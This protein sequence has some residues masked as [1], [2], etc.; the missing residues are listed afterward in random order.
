MADV[1]TLADRVRT[2]ERAV[3]DGECEF[4][5]ATTLAEVEARVET[6]EE[7]IEDLDDRATELEAA[8]QAL[9]GY[10]GNVRSVNEDVEQR[11]DAALAATERL[12]ARLD[13]ERSGKDET[14]SVNRSSA[15]RQ[16]AGVVESPH[17]G[18]V[19]GSRRGAET[20]TD[21]QGGR[22]DDGL[23]DGPGNGN[24]R[25]EFPEEA[26]APSSPD[27]VAPDSASEPTDP[28]L[29]ARIRAHL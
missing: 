15:F 29:L 14:A 20:A 26:G 7:R 10:V 19:D 27:P 4:P 25:T 24:A 13:D 8:T 6:V 9:R 18:P 21:Q 11:A 22:D 28:G 23:G 17:E 12:E 2:V 16:G 5:D 1:E 3:T